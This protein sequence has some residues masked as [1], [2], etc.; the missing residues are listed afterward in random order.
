MDK[1]FG[2]R[3]LRSFLAFPLLSFP[4]GP[5]GLH[6][7]V[8]ECRISLFFIQSSKSVIQ[9]LRHAWKLHDSTIS[10]WAIKFN[11]VLLQ[12]PPISPLLLLPLFFLAQQCLACW[13]RDKLNKK[14]DYWMRRRRF[15]PR[16][17]TTSNY[18]ENAKAAVEDG[19]SFACSCLFWLSLVLPSCI[20]VCRSSKISF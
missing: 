17:S 15:L 19:N 5:H 3:P 9:L 12:R 11:H 20:L 4:A 10:L 16:A 7:G 8:H 18:S 1:P 6:M 2:A 14:R 13:Q